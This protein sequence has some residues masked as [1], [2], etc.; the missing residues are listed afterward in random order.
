MSVPKLRFLYWGVSVRVLF[1]EFNPFPHFD[2][3]MIMTRTDSETAFVQPPRML[4]PQEAAKTPTSPEWLVRVQ[5]RLRTEVGEE[6]YSSW[7]ARM[8]VDGIE[9]KPSN[10]PCPRAFSRAGS[11]PITRRKSWLV[12]RPSGQKSFASS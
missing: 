4:R 9:A 7:F 2:R 11:N 5:E 12:A 6:V 1:S 8:E 3:E 10:C